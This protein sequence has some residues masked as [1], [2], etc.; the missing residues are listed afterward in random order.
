M[1][2][3]Q[4]VG[5]RDGCQR[6]GGETETTACRLDRTWW[7][8]AGSVMVPGTGAMRKAGFGGRDTIS[9]FPRSQQLY[10]CLELLGCRDARA[11]GRIDFCPG[12]R[13]QALASG[14]SLSPLS[15]TF[16]QGL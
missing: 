7:L 11:G 10:L 15:S 12:S 14:S 9:D 1:L 16:S 2:S 3:F 5:Q 6:Q 4:A 8:T 13:C